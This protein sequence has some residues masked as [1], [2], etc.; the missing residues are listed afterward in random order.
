MK[1]KWKK[2]QITCG[3]PCRNITLATKSL[4][5]SHSTISHKSVCVCNTQIV[6]FS[7]NKFH[8]FFSEEYF[9]S[10]GYY[11]LFIYLLFIF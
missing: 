9:W 4:C 6:S 10:F 1:Q 3:I 2:A 7:F 11:Y 5:K 8:I